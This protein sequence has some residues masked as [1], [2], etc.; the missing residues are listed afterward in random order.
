MSDPSVK[1]PPDEATPRAVRVAFQGERGAYSEEAVHRLCPQS[2]PVPYP[3][4][5]RVFD[6]LISGEVDIAVIPIENSLFGSIHVNYDLLRTHDVRITG[7]HHLR[8][9]HHLMTKPGVS[10]ADVKQVFSHPQA[11][12]QCA[13]YLKNQLPHAEAEAYYDTAGAAMM[14][15]TSTR[16]DIAAIASAQAAAQYGLEIHAGGIET[17]QANYTRFLRLH[18]PPDAESLVTDRSSPTSSQGRM[19]TSIVYALAQN[20]PGSLYK[21]LAAFALREVDL[22][23]IESR[24]LVGK[25][26]EYLFYL[27]LAGTMDDTPIQ[28][29]IDHLH[30]MTTEFKWIGSYPATSSSV[31]D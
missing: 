11:L 17:N 7:Q 15:S 12:G 14:V 26:G 31:E 27:D 4:F 23:K 5:D 22:L 24:P 18:R 1:T 6:A 28:R 20:I 21:S 9:K 25:P 8:I 10:L 30:E 13:V 2:T 16:R 19:I 3:Q 29:A